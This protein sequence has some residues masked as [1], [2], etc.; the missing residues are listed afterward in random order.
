MVVMCEYVH[1]L[2]MYGTNVECSHDAAVMSISE[3]V[4]TV[5]HA[6]MMQP[7]TE[8]TLVNYWIN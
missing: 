3:R 4:N 1:G 7:C 5:V 2:H 8:F 6:V